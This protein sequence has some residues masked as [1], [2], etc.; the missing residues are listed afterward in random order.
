MALLVLAQG[1][2]GIAQKTAGPLQPRKD[3]TISPMSAPESVSV[4][5]SNMQGTPSAVL[6][7]LKATEESGKIVVS[8][9]TKGPVDYNAFT[10]SQPRRLVVDFK[11]AEFKLAV[12]RAGGEP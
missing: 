4:P 12:Q 8:V 3:S 11:N 7:A 2:E 9:S 10:L 6:T 5:G 1:I